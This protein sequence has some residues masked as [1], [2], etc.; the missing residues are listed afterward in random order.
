MKMKKMTT[1]LALA[2]TINAAGAVIAV[3][4]VQAQENT[5]VELKSDETVSMDQVQKFDKFVHYNENSRLYEIDA[6][7]KDNL[8]PSEYQ[9]LEKAINNANSYLGT[10]DFNTGDLVEIVDANNSYLYANNEIV[11]DPNNYNDSLARATK[12]KEGVNKVVTYWWGVDVYIKKSTIR[13]AGNGAT[14][15]GIWIPQPIIGKVLSTCGVAYSNA[16][17]GI[18][19]RYNF[20]KGGIGSVTGGGLYGS[21]LGIEKV[22]WQ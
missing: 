17:G 13:L 16:P 9:E 20:V 2:L 14:V 7:A 11:K 15:A 12:Y 6:T 19:F 1:T 5:S 3:P 18:A 4:Q 22:W 21:P 8:D 10:I